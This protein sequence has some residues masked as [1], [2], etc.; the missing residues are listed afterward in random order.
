MKYELLLTKTERQ[1]VELEADSAEQA[2][3]QTRAA[4]PGWQCDIATE[5]KD[6]EP[7]MDFEVIATCEACDRL[8]FDIDDHNCDE[9]GLSFCNTCARSS[10]EE[11]ELP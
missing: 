8:I 6:G 3:K 7:I 9:E 10:R 5:I 2:I 1:V 4:N 11:E